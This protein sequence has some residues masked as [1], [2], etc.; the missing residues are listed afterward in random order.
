MNGKKAKLIRK[1]ARQKTTEQNKY[2]E[3]WGG[4]GTLKKRTLTDTSPKRIAQELK[5]EIN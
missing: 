3:V 5:N 4:Y 1:L 2:Q